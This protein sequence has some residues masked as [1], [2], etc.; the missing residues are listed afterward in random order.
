[1]NKLNSILSSYLTSLCL[2]ICAMSLTVSLTHTHT[3]TWQETHSM[4]PHHRHNY[5]TQ[6]GLHALPHV[7]QLAPA[8]DNSCTLSRK[9]SV[10]AYFSFCCL[11]TSERN[12][13]T[14]RRTHILY[15]EH[16]H[17]CVRARA[18]L[19]TSLYLNT[20]VHVNIFTSNRNNHCSLFSF[21]LAELCACA[22]TAME[23][24]KTETRDVPTAAVKSSKC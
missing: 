9:T 2:Y 14:H 23:K 18:L 10:P 1:M 17:V 20:R 22:N 12:T 7:L 13:Q 24:I 21:C 5:L 11:V 8:T 16:V 19:N 4:A 6:S 15:I 3:H